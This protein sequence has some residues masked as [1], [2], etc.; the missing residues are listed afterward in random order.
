M[1]KEERDDFRGY[2][3]NATDAQLEGI[4]EKERAAVTRA[5]ASVDR[6]VCLAIAESEREFR[7]R[8]GK[9]TPVRDPRFR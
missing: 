3:R 2:C 9:A 6:T 8:P 7:L 5:P 4:I 1:T